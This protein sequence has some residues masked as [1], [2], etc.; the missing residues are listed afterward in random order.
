M[1]NDSIN[2]VQ[3]NAIV[4]ERA[5]LNPTRPIEH[6]TMELY[7]LDQSYHDNVVTFVVEASGYT[8]SSCT[9]FIDDFSITSGQDPDGEIARGQERTW[10][11]GT[12]GFFTFRVGRKKSTGVA[13]FWRNNFARSESSFNDYPSELNFALYG[14]LDFRVNHGGGTSKVYRIAKCG[15][16]QGQTFF[17]NNWWI[18]VGGAIYK[19]DNRIICEAV[20]TTGEKLYFTFYRG[21]NRPVTVNEIDI[22]A[23]S[24]SP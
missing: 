7:L 12:S 20:A 23:I 2:D 6:L 14:P 13:N 11:S 22:T 1:S 3:T 4:E 21:S 17:S 8:I 19:G 18:A 10:T 9:F 5:S 16:A 15:L 24:T